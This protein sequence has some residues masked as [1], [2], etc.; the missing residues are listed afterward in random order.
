TGT[1]TPQ[2]RPGPRAPADA[3][4]VDAAFDERAPFRT[5]SPRLAERQR[6]R[7]GPFAGLPYQRLDTLLARMTTQQ[8]TAALRLVN[9]FPP[10]FLAVWRAVD[11]ATTRRK[12]REVRQLW[13]TA[14]HEE[15]RRLA[16]RTLNDYRRRFWRRVRRHPELMQMLRDAG[17]EFE[18]GRSTAPFWR[19]PNGTKE[20]LSI[21]HTDRVTDAPWRSVEGAGMRMISV[22]E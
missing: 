4:D 9:R 2:A 19:L 14:R 18:G 7:T 17:L 1:A 11:N 22:R 5:S 10:G 16:R 20:V 8:R 13:H 21:E 6:H 3:L 12:M 15:A